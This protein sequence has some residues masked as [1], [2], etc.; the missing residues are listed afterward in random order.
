MNEDQV[1]YWNGEAGA[2]WTAHQDILDLT[3]AP[4]GLA[5]VAAAAPAAGEKVLDIGCG[6][7]A[8]TL[9]LGRLVGPGGAVLGADI[10]APM[11]ARAQQRGAAA[12]NITVLEADAA[13]HAFAAGA[14]DLAF[15][16]FG[17]MFFEDP[18]LA[19]RNIRRALKPSGRLGFVC[20][21]GVKENIWVTSGLEVALRHVPRPEPTDPTAP[22]PFAFADPTR[23]EGILEAAGFT[24]IT[25][26]PFDADLMLG[27][28]GGPEAAA[29]FTLEIGPVGRLLADAGAEVKQRV[30]D[31]LVARYREMTDARGHVLAKAAVWIVTAKAAS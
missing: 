12:G 21:R 16:R 18:T 20:W 8:T 23:V 25:A 19:F 11:V 26:T 6:C 31:E 1:A 17:V 4:L 24:Q 5:A 15:S 30:R 7:G 14:H 22:G 13:S 10:S 2:K 9:E 28:E 3:L 29:E 27:G